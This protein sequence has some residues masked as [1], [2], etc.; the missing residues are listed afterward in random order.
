MIGLVANNKELSS[1]NQNCEKLASPLRLPASQHT[2]RFSKETGG[3]TNGTFFFFNGTG[4]L[5]Q[6]LCTELFFKF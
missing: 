5:T 6:G 2:N 3:D 4:N 1:E